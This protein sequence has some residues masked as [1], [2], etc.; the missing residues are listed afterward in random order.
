MGFCV[1]QNLLKNEHPF[2]QQFLFL[3]FCFF[4]KPYLSCNMTS[5]QCPSPGLKSFLLGKRQTPPGSAKECKVIITSKLLC[6][7][8]QLRTGE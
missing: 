3:G 7:L 8:L 6:I 4:L 1:K 2:R 5:N